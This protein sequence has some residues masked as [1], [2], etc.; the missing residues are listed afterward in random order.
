VE[1]LGKVTL[2]LGEHYEGGESRQAEPGQ[3]HLQVLPQHYKELLRN[4]TYLYF[5]IM[6]HFPRENCLLAKMSLK[7]ANVH[8]DY[9]F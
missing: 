2:N 9:I 4:D 6:I 3:V 1:L 5:A 7:R 8:E